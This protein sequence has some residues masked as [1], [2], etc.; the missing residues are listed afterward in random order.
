MYGLQPTHGLVPYTGVF[1]IETT[2]DHTGPMTATVADNA[3]LLG[4]LA[5][6]T[7]STRAR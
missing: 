2:R 1:P 3:L 6:P 7:G 4:V 5:G